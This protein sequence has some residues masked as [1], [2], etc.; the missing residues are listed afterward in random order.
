MTIQKL[1][2]YSKPNCV[3]CTASARKLAGMAVVGTEGSGINVKPVPLDSGIELEYVDVSKSPDVAAALIA[4]GFSSTPVL[5]FR[6]SDGES[7]IAFSG[8]DPDS[9]EAAVK[10]MWSH[11]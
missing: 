2:F 3:Q 9:I 7:E 5:D 6:N 10:L 4:R 11:E 8:F 1:V